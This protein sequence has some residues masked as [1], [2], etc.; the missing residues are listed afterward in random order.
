MLEQY[1]QP[2]QNEY[3]SAKQFRF[4][5]KPVTAAVSQQDAYKRKNKRD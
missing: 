5:S 2:D 3:D 1:F 4:A